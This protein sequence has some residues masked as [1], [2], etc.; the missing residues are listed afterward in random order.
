MNMTK[1]FDYGFMIGFALFYVV[2]GIVIL[3]SL[4]AIIIGLLVHYVKL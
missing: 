1:Q 4:T 3:V 2:L